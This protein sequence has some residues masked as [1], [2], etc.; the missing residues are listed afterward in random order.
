MPPKRVFVLNGHPGETSLVGHLTDA[1][2]TAAREAGHD[3]R[4]IHLH[5]MAFD[6]DRGKAGYDDAK[7]LEPVLEEALQN[8]EWCQH[9]VLSTPMWWGGVPAKLKGFI[10][11]TLMPGRTFTTRETDWMG[12]PKPLLTGRTARV[13]MTSDTPDWFLRFVYARAIKKQLRGQVLEFVGFRP[14]RITHF[15]GASDPKPGALDRWVTEVSGLGTA[16]A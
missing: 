5:D 9:L 7:P 14:T 11:R 3:I 13:I 15:A 8:L 12:M 4:R 10:D 1:Y 6:P 16:A 2:A